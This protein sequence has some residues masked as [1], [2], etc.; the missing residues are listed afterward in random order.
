MPVN[1]RT[2]KHIRSIL[3]D[4]YED[5]RLKLKNP[6][7]D[8]APKGNGQTASIT[9]PTERTKGKAAGRKRKAR[10]AEDEEDVEEVE[11][12]EE[13]GRPPK[14][15]R[16][17]KEDDQANA[18]DR[19]TGGTRRLDRKTKDDDD[20]K[21]KV[22]LGDE[23]PSSSRGRPVNGR[24][25][26]KAKVEALLELDEKREDDAPGDVEVAAAADEEGES[27]ELA[28]INGIKPKVYLKDGDETE[29]TSMTRYA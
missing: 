13:K 19:R 26:D 18:G 6:D 9:Q 17:A 7:S 3:G 22:E 1:A 29:V 5:A 15:T 10:D 21:E 11:E 20:S 27:D 16:A 2:C 23:E 12:G 28:E 8:A 25:R 4:K 14:R 24:T